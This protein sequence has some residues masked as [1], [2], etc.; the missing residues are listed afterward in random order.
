MQRRELFRLLGAGAVPPVFNSDVLA[1]FQAAQ[2]KSGYALRTL[3]PHQNATLSYL[4]FKHM[5]R[6]C[7]IRRFL[8]R[9]LIA[10]GGCQKSKPLLL[11]AIS[12]FDGGSQK[13]NGWH[14]A[15]CFLHSED[16]V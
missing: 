7:R 12:K 3:N 16:A 5:R 15:S 9:V 11:A 6:L 13:E 2:A 8:D 10:D 1:M 14:I 4:Q